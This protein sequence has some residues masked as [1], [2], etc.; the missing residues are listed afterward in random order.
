MKKE[1]RKRE[2]MELPAIRDNELR[3]VFD[4]F[5]L[6][7]KVDSGVLLCA[8][9]SKIIEWENIGALLVKN[10]TLEIYCDTSECIEEVS[11]EQ[12]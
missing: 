4:R 6:A 8:S 9:C 2:D 1:R 5:D 11:K 12:K 7:D 3:A 10:G